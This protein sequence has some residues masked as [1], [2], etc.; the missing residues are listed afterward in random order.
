MK[1]YK[2][3]EE[4]RKLKAYHNEI[5]KWSFDDFKI[6]ITRKNK[7]INIIFIIVLVSL[8]VAS[9]AVMF[10]GSLA[11]ELYVDEKADDKAMINIGNHLCEQINQTN[12]NVEIYQSGKVVVVCNKESLI[13]G[14]EE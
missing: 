7:V 9:M 6:H 3:L 10:F 13:I 12:I 5:R 2:E 11:L 4:E 1:T 8:L 14:G